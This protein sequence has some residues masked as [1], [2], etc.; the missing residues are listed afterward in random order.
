[1]RNIEICGKSNI[2]TTIL[3]IAIL[4]NPQR[5]LFSGELHHWA[6]NKNSH[7]NVLFV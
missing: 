7:H 2:E 6:E 1:M 3:F 4:F 5:R